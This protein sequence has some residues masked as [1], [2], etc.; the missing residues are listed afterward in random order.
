MIICLN[1]F[2]LF[3]FEKFIKKDSLF[4]ANN[5]YPPNIKKLRNKEKLN[6][7]SDYLCIRMYK[8]ILKSIDFIKL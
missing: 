6:I 4:K 2:T 3:L 5:I 1:R 8:G 7:L